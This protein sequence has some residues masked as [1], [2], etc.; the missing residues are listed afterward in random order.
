MDHPEHPELNTLDLVTFYTKPS[1]KDG[2]TRHW[3]VFGPKQS[4]RSP[5]GTCTNARMAVLYAKG[6]L[7]LGDE[8][9]AESTISTFHRGRILE[10]LKIGEYRGI[11]PEVSATAYIVAFNQM[12]IDPEDPLKDGFLF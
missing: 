1:V 12:V 2:D 8:F 5:A 6:E 11:L 10:E 7:K 9:V 3:N 4:C